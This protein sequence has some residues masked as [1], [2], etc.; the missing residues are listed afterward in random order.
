MRSLPARSA[1]F[2]RTQYI[3]AAIIPAVIL[4]LSIT[5]FVWAQKN[6]TVVVDGRVS[7]LNTQANDVAGV[8]RQ[9]RISI[10]DGD[11]LSPKADAEVT[12][13]MTVVVRNAIPVTVRIGDVE[14]RVEVVGTTV[15]DA[16]MA[17]GANISPDAEVTPS[18]ET[19]LNTNMVINAPQRFTRVKTHDVVVPFKTETFSDSSLPRGT[20]QIIVA[21]A[22]GLKMQVTKTVVADGV[23][24]EPTVTAEKVITPAQSQLE[25]LGPGVSAKAVGEA[26]VIPAK[27]TR[28]SS[29]PQTGRRMRL[30]STAY[31]PSEP[32][33]GGG[34]STA[35]GHPAVFGVAAVDPRVIPLGSRLYVVGYG[36]AMAYDTGGAIKGDRIDLCFDT[37][38]ECER[39]G[40]KP[41]TVIV[42][43]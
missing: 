34:P 23:E 43:D 7:H 10:S 36:Y 16:L 24:G 13:G 35:M 26:R 27:N 31:S 1:R 17:V 30:I 3:V 37:G 41:V 9:A 6:V 38:A 39:W 25:A 5:G 22:T 14:T 20:R 28:G 18:L 42:L 15:A 11:V 2:F 4:S 12:D 40:R 19:K 29:K 8:L 33:G 21:G 32:G